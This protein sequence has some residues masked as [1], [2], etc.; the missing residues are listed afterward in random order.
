M[1]IKHAP[2]SSL[3]GKRPGTHYTGSWVDQ[4]GRVP[5]P[6]PTSGFEP[7]T[8]QLVTSRYTDYAVPAVS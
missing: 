3:P 1:K 2:P 5:K 4:S 8:V 7:R 6:S